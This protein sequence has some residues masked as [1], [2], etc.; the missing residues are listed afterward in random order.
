MLSNIERELAGGDLD[1]RKFPF[2]YSGMTYK[3]TWR[4]LANAEKVR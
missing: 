3:F 2:E 1:L 4:T